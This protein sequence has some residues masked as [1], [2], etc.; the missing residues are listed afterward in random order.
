MLIEQ[1]E[2]QGVF[3]DELQAQVGKD[4]DPF[5]LVCHVAF[6]QP[7]LTRKERADNVKKSHYRAKYGD[8]ARQV[9]TYLLDSYADQGI[10]AIEQIDVLK[11]NPFSQLGQPIEIINDIF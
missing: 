1:L 6:D 8:Q 7:P 5:D 2:E 9:I 11:V 4:L 10:E 3:L